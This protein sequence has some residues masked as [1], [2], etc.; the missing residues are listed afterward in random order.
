V[1]KAGAGGNWTLSH[2]PDYDGDYTANSIGISGIVHVLAFGINGHADDKVEQ[3]AMFV[4]QANAPAAGWTSLGKIDGRAM[5][6]WLSS[7]VSMSNNGRLAAASSRKGYVS[8]FK[9]NEA[10]A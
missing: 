2:D 5:T 7:Q 10:K 4:S 9:V 6:D 1:L 3:C 8:F